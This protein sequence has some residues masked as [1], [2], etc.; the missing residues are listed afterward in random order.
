MIG[1]AFNNKFDVSAYIQFTRYKWFFITVSSQT[2]QPCTR[3]SPT[4]RLFFYYFFFVSFF[5][6]NSDA[7]LFRIELV[8]E[9]KTDKKLRKIILALMDR[10]HHSEILI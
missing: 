9:R 1:R 7:S 2:L 3:E 6:I 5:V 8:N 10:H 4:D